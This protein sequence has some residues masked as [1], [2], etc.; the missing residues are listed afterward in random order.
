MAAKNL[1]DRETTVSFALAKSIAEEKYRQA[2]ECIKKEL[3]NR[4]LDGCE[5]VFELHHMIREYLDGGSSL[6]SL[7]EATAKAKLVAR[8]WSAN[9][10]YNEYD[11]DNLNP[12]S[13]VIAAATVARYTTISQ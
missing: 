7:D 5:A 1:N 6:I 3:P 10:W 9:G 11:Q 2:D 13:F 12:A 4:D 8:K